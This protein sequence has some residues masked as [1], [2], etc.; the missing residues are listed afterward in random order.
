MEMVAKIYDH[1]EH[2]LLRQFA[3][4]DLQIRYLSGFNL[5]LNSAKPPE[6]YQQLSGNTAKKLHS[7]KFRVL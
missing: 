2:G 7:S 6:H 1:Y 3:L 5:V 4:L